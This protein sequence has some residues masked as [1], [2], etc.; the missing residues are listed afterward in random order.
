M[1]VQAL[2]TLVKKHLRYHPQKATHRVREV[3]ALGREQHRA[4]CPPWEG[5]LIFELITQN[6]YR[7][8]LETGFGTGSTA[9][10]MLAATELGGGKVTSLD[11]SEQN[12]N[13]IG[14][15]NVCASGFEARH[16]LYERPSFEVMA[17]F[18]TEGRQFDFVFIDGWKTFDYLAYETFIIN[19]MMP[20]GGCLMFDDSNLPSVQKL[21]RMLKA[22]YL[23]REI[24]YSRYGQSPKLRLYHILT[25][26]STARPYRA[27]IK[28]VDTEEQPPLQDWTFYARF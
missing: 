17:E 19:R 4:Y 23:F 28:T 6:G 7:D 21:I 12:F 18:L 13:D 5:D 11:W 1:P 25:T 10:Y 16:A 9:I 24:D 14:K 8:C 15:D 22:H 2:K 20:K 26:R 3:L 27:I